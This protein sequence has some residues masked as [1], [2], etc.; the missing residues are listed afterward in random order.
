VTRSAD[1]LDEVLDRLDA[2]D[3]RGDDDG[4]RETL[5]AALERFPDAAP[6][7]EWETSL[8][9]DDERLDEALAILDNLVADDPG[10][11]WARRERAAVLID[12]GRFAPALADL[13]ALPRRAQRGLAAAER[14][15]IHADLGLCLDRLGRPADADAEFR[16]AA[17]LDPE[18]CPFPPRLS[19]ARFEALVAAALDTIPARFRRYLD[20]VV[21]VVRDYPAP[22]DPDPFLLG[23]YVG[24]PRAERT[25]ATADHLDHVIVFKRPHELRCRDEDGLRDEVQRTVVHE[26]AHHFGLE[27]EEMDEEYR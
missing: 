23:L 16:H 2:L 27:D 8:L 18:G 7:R 15:S 11:D 10:N 20:Q 3:A 19:E 26:L 9:V 12:L 24:V 25:L 1:A 22:D 6:L 13:R 4:L 21:T 17:T 5:A 14:A